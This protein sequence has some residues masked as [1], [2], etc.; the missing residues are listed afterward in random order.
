VTRP[1]VGATPVVGAGLARIRC[2]QPRHRAAVNAPAVKLMKFALAMGQRREAQPNLS[3]ECIGCGKP[4]IAKCG[5][6]RV[7]HWAHKG[8]RICDPWWEKETEW[9]RGWKNHFPAEC[10]E[11]VHYAPDGERHVA[12]VKTRDGWVIEFQHSSIKPDER[13]SREAFYPRLIWVVDG[14]RRQRDLTQF[15]KAWAGGESTDPFTFNTKRRVRSPEG[16]L[17]RDWAGSRAHVFFDFGDQRFL[18]WLF[19]HNNGAGAYLQCVS[20]QQLVRAVQASGLGEFD[21]LVNNFRAFVARYE[22]PAGIPAS[23]GRESLV[24]RPA[25]RM[26]MLRRRFRF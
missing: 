21:L 19:P 4:V 24:P 18:W 10:Q 16:A 15:A 9:H 12:D 25:G 14:A 2:R 20:R 13:R 5:E 7:P 22:P 6:V 1:I 26:P 23:P 8:R 11:I 17:M 3:G